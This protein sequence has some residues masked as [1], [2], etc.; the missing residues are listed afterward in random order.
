[1]EKEVFL[2][3]FVY[4]FLTIIHLSSF[5]IMFRR[6]THYLPSLTRLAP[7]LLVQMVLMRYIP[8][9]FS[10]LG[11]GLC[12]YLLKDKVVA[13][14]LSSFYL[15]FLPV[16]INDAFSSFY[17]LV[18]QHQ[19]SSY[20]DIIIC[21]TLA[22]FLGIL[23][24]YVILYFFQVDYRQLLVKTRELEEDFYWPQL[25]PAILAFFYLTLI[26]HFFVLDLVNKEIVFSGLIG[27]WTILGFIA[28]IFYHSY[29]KRYA[30]RLLDLELEHIKRK[31]LRYLEMYSQYLEDYYS[32][33]RVFQHDYQNILL[34]LREAIQSKDII[35][36]S[37]AREEILVPSL[38]R[39]KPTAVLEETDNPLV[40]LIDDYR[41]HLKQ[42]DLSLD[43][44][45]DLNIFEHLSA[46]LDSLVVLS[47]ML[48][49]AFSEIQR[50]HGDRIVLSCYR[51]LHQMVLTME[52]RGQLS[53]T[54]PLTSERFAM[55]RLL[56]SGRYDFKLTVDQ[57]RC[58]Q[59]LRIG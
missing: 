53:Y 15:V 14:K 51:E 29:L 20:W 49:Y 42:F 59:E 38:S 26:H 6:A 28:V 48:D 45:G 36:L 41:N 8:F 54:L 32:K 23:T 34:S 33:L 37:E 13:Y 27:N 31:Q 12:Y 30:K 25:I 5:C 22:H 24:F 44:V 43:V 17:M 46:D 7:L 1:M 2:V 56:D 58:Y 52:V 19:V 47:L 21:Y 10:V 57:E 50:R 40:L 16:F 4:Y 55:N 18:L 11:L 9:H 3:D 39:L 35:K